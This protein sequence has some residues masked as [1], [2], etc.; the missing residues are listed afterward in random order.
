MDPNIS[1]QLTQQEQPIIP[2]VP[3]QP[4]SETPIA[5][6][7]LDTPKKGKLK[8]IWIVVVVIILL[9][10]GTGGFYLESKRTVTQKLQNV[11]VKPITTPTIKPST[12]WKIY[13][14]TDYG[15]QLTFTDKFKGY[16]AKK[17]SIPSSIIESPGSP[18]VKYA[19]SLPTT[20]Q[21]YVIYGNNPAQVFD[22]N[23]YSQ[24]KWD[25]VVKQGVQKSTI[26]ISSNG[27]VFTY[28]LASQWPSDWQLQGGQNN[29]VKPV[30][31]SFKFIN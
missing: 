25:W 27:K 11:G 22:I 12:N 29:D 9:I 3:V 2:N 19:F 6:P 8:F 10:V 17:I 26:I 18:L 28:A 13:T 30:I 15:F 31:D 23:V 24:D 21:Q 1:N 7:I 20:D 16:T 5:Q 4:V 14:N